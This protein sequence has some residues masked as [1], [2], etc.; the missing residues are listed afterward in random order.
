MTKD[1]IRILHLE[2]DT[3]DAELIHAKLATD[4]FKCDIVRVQDRQSFEAAITQDFFDL[5]MSDF[6]VPQYDGFSALKFA[7]E[8]HPEIPFILVSGTLG[9]EQAVTSLK[10]GA[11]DYIVKQ[12][13][14]RLV[15]AVSRALSDARD[16]KEHEATERRLRE[17]AQAS[18][19]KF[20]TLVEQALVGIYVIEGD[21]FVYVNPGLAMMLGYSA[22][23]MTSQ[24]F[25]DF[26][27]PEDREFVRE[28][29]RQ[30]LDGE[31]V[32]PN[33][34]L[35]M[36]RCNQSV[37]FVEACG[38]RVDFNG[39]PAVMG[40]LLDITERKLAENAVR[41]TEELYRRA[42]V[43]S[44]A[45]PY[46]FDYKTGTYPFI[47]EGIEQLTGYRPEEIST[48]LWQS[49][50]TESVML[51]DAAGMTKEEAGQRALQTRI[52][53]WGCDMRIL[54][55]EGKVR[56]I[57]DMAV[58]NLDESG[59]PIGSMGILQDITER[60]QAEERIREQ[61]ELLDKA[62]DAIC[63][64]DLGQQILYWNKSAERLYGWTAAEAIGRNA[65][66]LLF[67]G[68]FRA[69][70]K[71]IPNLIRDGEWKGQL[72]QVTR[73]GQ[74]LIAESRWSLLR[75][76]SG[77]PKSV[78]II[79]TDIT[80]K[81]QTEAKL[82]RTQ[83]MESIGALAGGIAH[84]LNNSLAPIL[85]AAELIREEL[86]T[87]EGKA[88]LETM[89][90]SAQRGA[91]MVRQ[92]L[93]FSRGVTGEHVPLQLRSLVEDMEKFS[94]STFPRSIRVASQIEDNV[95]EILGDGTQI[96][97]VLLNLCINARDAMPAGG[98]LLMKV[99][100]A[101]VGPSHPGRQVEGAHML[102]SVIDSG[103]GMPAEVIGK[104]F[105]PFF[106][107]KEIGKGTGLG[108]STVIEIVKTHRGFV[109]VSSELGKGTT[110]NVFLPAAPCEAPLIDPNRAD[111]PTGAGELILL[112]DDD[113]ALLEMSKLV[114][115]AYNYQILAA[116]DGAEG[117]ELYKRHH[118]D[119]KVVITDMIMPEMSGSELIAKIRELK[120]QVR[121]IGLSGL[122][123]ESWATT[124][125]NDITVLKK[126]FSTA[127]LL[128]KLHELAR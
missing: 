122:D 80:E 9:E 117:L 23:Q 72:E 48:A 103:Q 29:V 30:R 62:Q 21:R 107:T 87:E 47:G 127:T 101:E 55:R 106:T 18:E 86:Q 58:Q 53:Q 97:Q 90:N 77:N 63:V 42:I 88:L 12:R 71:A 99:R 75:D 10:N 83:R 84:D 125:G 20:R 50:V 27:F 34:N 28:N 66:E 24:P 119:I 41:R 73:T 54:T 45:V 39:R 91:D 8:I 51:G 19:S 37:A 5:V 98:Q 105:E 74:K 2:D 6:S 108:L 68:D 59:T 16:R 82:L 33:C 109:E 104:I 32:E 76:E 52:K 118:Q 15:P 25:V 128:C 14:E 35:R 93:S 92:I 111:P 94:R 124:T 60:K 81:R 112:V 64:N 4:Q 79:N 36:L 113:I 96:H 100:R 70:V 126:P 116:K 44:G 123:S 43:G 61:A 65:N 57:S 3:M 11:T 115:E 46:A 102:L 38:S 22:G 85:M 13:L 69:T 1:A 31:K 114:L 67:Q 17:E 120:P 121:I 26:I 78:L 49:I 95:A 89:V 40:T 110:F 7:R 56:W